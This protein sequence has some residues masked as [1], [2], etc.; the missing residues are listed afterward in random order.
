MNDRRLC[1]TMM[2]ALAMSVGMP[3]PTTRADTVDGLVSF[4]AGTTARANEVNDNFTEVADS[5]NDNDARIAALEDEIA[6]LRE[7]LGNVLNV[8]R[9]LSLETVNDQPTVRLTGA[10]LQIVNGL[11]ETATANGTGNVLIGYDERRDPVFHRP[12]CSLGINPDDKRPIESE[13][14][15]NDAGGTFAHNLTGGS[16]YLVVGPEHNYTRWAGIVVGTKNTSNYDF[17]SV[18]GGSSNVAGGHSA[19]VSGGWENRAIASGASVTG[20]IFNTAGGVSSHV[21]GGTSNIAEGHESTVTGGTSNTA[22]GFYSSV[23]G[24]AENLASGSASSVSGGSSGTA[25]GR[26]SSVSGGAENTASGESSSVLAGLRNRAEGEFAGVGGG[27]SN[28]ASG[29][30]S[31]VSGGDSREASGASAWAAGSLAEPF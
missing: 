11:G 8:N 18:S 21:S 31:S 26:T 12:E 23:S 16:H 15:C 3:V 6:M 25:S 22:S 19:S 9:Y 27:L 24:G 29:I 14:A 5:V 10:N 28:V 20:G 30:N 2:A 7:Q 17:A 1:L 13:L 4:S